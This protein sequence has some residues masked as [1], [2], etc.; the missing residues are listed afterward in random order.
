MIE[1]CWDTI[2]N[3]KYLLLDSQIVQKAQID[4]KMSSTEIVLSQEQFFHT[5]LKFVINLEVFLFQQTNTKRKSKNE[6]FLLTQMLFE[7]NY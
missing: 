3:H 4:F 6:M 5:F 1:V 7:K 2:C